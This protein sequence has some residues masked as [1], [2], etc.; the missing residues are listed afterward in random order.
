MPVS[1]FSVSPWE[2]VMPVRLFSLLLMATLVASAGCAARARNIA[3]LKDDPGRFS[4]R[5][6]EVTGRVTSAWNVP[7]IPYRLYKIDDGTAEITV[8]SQRNASPAR[9]ALVRVRGPVRELASFG[10]NS[11]GL[12]IEEHNRRLLRR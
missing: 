4:D 2:V 6:V 9:G 1:W 10:G 7:L 3:D 11:V 5:S 8:I 12:H